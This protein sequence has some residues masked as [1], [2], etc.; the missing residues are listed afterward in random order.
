MVKIYNGDLI[1]EMREGA[2]IMLS[3][4]G[5][6]SEITD[7]VVPVME[8]NP[9]L[10]RKISIIKTASLTNGTAA[11]IVTAPT[12][13]DFFICGI[14]LSVIKDVT[15]TSLATDVRTTINGNVATLMIISGQ[16]LTAQSAT[17]SISFSNP[18]KVDK[19]ANV[20]LNHTT[21]V[22]NIRGDAIVYGYYVENSNV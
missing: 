13:R 21:N 18:I 17:M 14:T 5:V 19:G 6:P 16:T 3:A 15:S 22:A 4:D 2:K 7:K 12:D 9:N 20:T 8:C 10:F 11:T 1:K